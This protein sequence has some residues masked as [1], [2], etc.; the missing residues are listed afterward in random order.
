MGSGT[1]EWLGWTATTTTLKW[2][3]NPK[4]ERRAVMLFQ[5]VDRSKPGTLSFFPV[6]AE[7]RSKSG[8]LS[9]RICAFRANLISYF[10][11]CITISAKPTV[12]LES[13]LLFKFS[14]QKALT[15]EARLDVRM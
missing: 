4:E 8:K 9:Y 15:L 2:K 7:Y 10:Y 1:G 11:F 5:V 13:H 6:P 3:E 14:V 12:I